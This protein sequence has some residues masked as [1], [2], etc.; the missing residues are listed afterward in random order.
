MAAPLPNAHRAALACARRL[1]PGSAALLGGVILLG[2]TAAG[3]G[4]SAFEDHR[5]SYL[6]QCDAGAYRTHGHQPCLWAWLETN[7]HPSWVS[8]AIGTLLADGC[9]SGGCEPWYVFS[10]AYRVPT[11]ISIPIRYPDRIGAQDRDRI[12]Q[13]FAAHH[14]DMWGANPNQQ[15]Q[16]QVGLYLYARYFAPGLSF[17]YDSGRTI[18]A[19]GRT[20]PPTAAPTCAEAPTTCSSSPA[21]G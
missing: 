14:R 4:S 20:S 8:Q 6:D 18:R 13:S 10:T 17:T 11:L 1:G 16:Q 7:G 19:S 9:Y 21:T 15:L 2:G 5:R 12:L 3:E